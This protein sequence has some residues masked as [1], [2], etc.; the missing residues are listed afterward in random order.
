MRKCPHN[1][2]KY[3]C[4]DCGGS[5]LCEHDRRK[6]RCKDCGGS[7]ICSHKRLKRLCKDCGG[8]DICEHN[9]RKDLCKDCGG[10]QICPHK[11]RKSRCKDCCGSEICDHVS[12]K[13]NCKECCGANICEHNRQRPQ[14]IICTP[15]CAC[16]LCKAVCVKKS[17]RFAPYCFRCY[18]YL[19]PD[20]DIPRQYKTKEYHLRDELKKHFKDVEMV[21]DKIIEGSCSKRR[22]DIRIECYTHTVIIECDENGHSNYQCENKRTME[23]FESLGSRPIVMLRFNPDNYRGETCFKLTKTGSLSLNKK[24]WNRRIAELVDLVEWY[25]GNIPDMEVTEEYI[26][27]NNK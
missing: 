27:Y 15:S 17:Y 13:S 1:K 9:I 16:Q 21:F 25:I 2:N 19:N 7:G 22:P 12:R 8:S 10:S 4:K 11:R 6:D 23:I 14:C 24:E 20:V 26:C 18:C 5:Q 3:Y